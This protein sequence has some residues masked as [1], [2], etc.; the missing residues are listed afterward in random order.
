MCLSGVNNL[1]RHPHSFHS[2]MV[3]ERD[4]SGV[5]LSAWCGI[6]KED[7]LSTST[8]ISQA[9]QTAVHRSKQ[10]VSF[11]P[12]FLSHVLYLMIAGLKECQALYNAAIT[13][14]KRKSGFDA[15]ILKILILQS[16][17]ESRN[18]WKLLG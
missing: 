8:E 18:L 5:A 3:K 16:F 7:N 1:L 12:D 15:R 14:E 4:I 10:S 9:E 17:A 6:F 11:L 13:C 2:G